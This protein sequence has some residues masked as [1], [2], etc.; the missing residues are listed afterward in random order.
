MPVPNPVTGIPS[1]MIFEAQL[2]IWN[3][4]SKLCKLASP[5]NTPISRLFILTLKIKKEM[6]IA[7]QIVQNMVNCHLFI[8]LIKRTKRD[9]TMRIQ[10][11]MSEI[12]ASE[13]NMNDP[14]NREAR[15]K[16]RMC[17]L[18]RFSINHW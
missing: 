8:F 11:L 6:S 5:L 14:Q 10:K 17:F 9:V 16:S 15:A 12:L 3:L 2:Q 4:G 18:S 7:E 1:D 13:K